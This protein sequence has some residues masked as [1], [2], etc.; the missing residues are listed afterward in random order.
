MNQP[1]FV[2]EFAH[3]VHGRVQRIKLSYKFLAYLFGF[4]IALSLLACL[5]FS[6][7]IRMSW[8]AHDYNELSANF[9]RLRTRYQD[10]QRQSREHKQQMASL[11]S[12]AS[13]VSAA[14]GISQPESD[15]GIMDSDAPNAK[16]S[17]EE[18]N[19]L[20]AATYSSIYHHY[21]YKWQ[22]HS[23]PSLWPVI[24][25]LSSSF[26]GRSDPFSGEGAF[27]TGVDLQAP[28]GTPVHVTADGV[29]V[30]AG[31]SG[32]YGK[33]VVVDHG[34]GLETYY[35]H[36]S[37]LMVMAG[38]EL[39]RGQVLGLSGGT[40]RATGP[41]LHYEVRLGGTP[42]NPY[43]FMSKAPTLSASRP[44]HNDFGL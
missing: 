33:L 38:Q 20:K 42:V 4:V 31:W 15:R 32:S 7:Y 19:F 37:Q 17:I 18:Y 39:R 44:V 9:E 41:H 5:L 27:H 28:R 24:G 8:K 30:S 22:A 10:L 26:G 3:S 36:L 11:E 16:E 13:E 14:Y 34:N 25:A 29:V 2:L 12:L 6:S 40:G 21:G 23:Q 1:Y 35:A 43:K